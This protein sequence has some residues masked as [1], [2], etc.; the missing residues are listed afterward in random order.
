MVENVFGLVIPEFLDDETS[1]L[2]R[3]FEEVRYNFPQYTLT[4]YLLDAKTFGCFARVRVWLAFHHR[5][6]GGQKA[7]NR[8]RQMIQVLSKLRT[9][10]F[11]V[12]DSFIHQYSFIQV[13]I[14]TEVI[15][16]R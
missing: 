6:A 5:R 8:Q 2:E 10:R 11:K 15:R 9:S 4:V 13:P 3:I 12:P 1:P 14:R 16:R 7:T